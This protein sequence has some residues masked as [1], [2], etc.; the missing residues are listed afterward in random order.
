MNWVGDFLIVAGMS[1]VFLG[2]ASKDGNASRWTLV[3]VPA[4]LT[5]YSIHPVL[6]LANYL[7]WQLFSDSFTTANI[8]LA[9]LM[10]LVKLLMIWTAYKVAIRKTDIKTK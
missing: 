7:P 8:G 3:T 9:A 5:L 4:L 6:V 10:H 1:I 2:L